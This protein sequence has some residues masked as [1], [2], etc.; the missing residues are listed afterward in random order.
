MSIYAIC[1]FQGLS[2]RGWT[3]PVPRPP[4]PQ[5]TRVA[6]CSLSGPR[7]GPA[8]RTDHCPPLAGFPPFPPFL[9]SL[10]LPLDMPPPDTYVKLPPI[11]LR[12]YHTAV[13]QS[14]T[15][16]AI[17][18]VPSRGPL[19]GGR[20]PDTTPL[21]S[22]HPWPRS[23]IHQA[24][25]TPIPHPVL[26]LPLRPG[27]VRPQPRIA[28]GIP[29]GGGGFL[30]KL[31]PSP[32]Q[33]VTSLHICEF[34]RTHLSTCASFFLPTVGLISRRIMPRLALCRR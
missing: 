14:L 32:H 7:W 15:A 4:F 27:C 31:L 17:R 9:N 22:A 18:L 13:R 16:P 26:C 2:P 23:P 34:T 3:A 8:N 10:P 21:P 30:P 5:K 6:R 33:V 1:P 28:Y 24:L 11:G 29:E 12:C 25:H 19:G 20:H